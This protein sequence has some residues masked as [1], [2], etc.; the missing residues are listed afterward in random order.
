[1]TTAEL[2]DLTGKWERGKIGDEEYVRAVWDYAFCCG[3]EG[4]R[5]VSINRDL[6][7]VPGNWKT[8]AE[9]WHAAAEFT[10]DRI[11]E[12]RM[13]ERE[14]GF[15]KKC[16][17]WYGEQGAL[18]LRMGLRDS[19]GGE[20]RE[21]CTSLRTLMRLDALLAEAKKGMR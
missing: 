14:I 11:E 16:A 9:A 19:A 3:I 7:K 8:D 1:M 5:F 4:S 15:L 21:Q 17:N 18:S 6:W 10:R 20:A 12:V 2:L 13:L